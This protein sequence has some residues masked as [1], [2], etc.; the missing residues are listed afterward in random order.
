MHVTRVCLHRMF[1]CLVQ[2]QPGAYLLT[3]HAKPSARASAFAAPVTPT[4]TEAD[5]RIAAPPVDGQA[6]AELLR[7][8]GELIERGFLAMTADHAE[9]VK[10]TS[11]A[12]VLA[13]DAAASATA[14]H[15]ATSRSGGGKKSGKQGKS[16]NVATTSSASSSMP[17]RGAGGSQRPDGS[18]TPPSAAAFPGRVEVS[19]VRGGTSREKTVLIVFPGTRA[20]LT[21]V[22]EKVSRE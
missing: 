4:L 20:E 10:D 6:N 9:Y 18:S 16:R 21:A 22:L 3:V 14:A 13:A 7:Y 17:H 1:P 5:L 12:T 8:L 19:L 15:S 2:V 11:Y